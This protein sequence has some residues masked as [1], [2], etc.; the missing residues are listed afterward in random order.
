MV[1]SKPKERV[2]PIKH[3]G[4]KDKNKDLIAQQKKMQVDDHA[5]AE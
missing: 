1:D 4:S 2:K 3:K 5:H